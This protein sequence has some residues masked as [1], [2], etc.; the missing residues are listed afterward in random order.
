MMKSARVIGIVSSGLSWLTLA[1]DAFAQTATQSAS[2]G[3][4]SGALPNAG[5]TGLTY[6]IFVGGV[7]LFVFGTI[8]LILS[9]RN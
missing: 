7:I 9:Y 1:T 2:K 4:T 6:L 3:G 5:T 8:K